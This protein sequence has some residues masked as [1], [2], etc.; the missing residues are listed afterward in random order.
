MDIIFMILILEHK[1]CDKNQDFS[2]LQ[3]AGRGMHAAN[4]SHE[5]GAGST[6]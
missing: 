2:L 6:L 3:N 4:L 1:N 5:K